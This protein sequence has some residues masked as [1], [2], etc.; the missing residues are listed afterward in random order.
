MSWAADYFN[1]HYFDI[2]GPGGRL[3]QEKLMKAQEAR[4]KAEK[5][6]KLLIT[7]AEREGKIAAAAKKKADAARHEKWLI[8]FRL[9]VERAIGW[10][11]QQGVTEWSHCLNEASNWSHELYGRDKYLTN[12]EFAPEMKIVMAE[13]ESN[14]YKVD[15]IDEQTSHDDSSAYANSGGE[16]GS[17]HPYHTYDTILKVRW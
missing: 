17:M 15:I 4:E 2:D 12:F 9:L 14:G 1:E 5:A 3:A 7:K 16:C 6:A 8:D 10:R 11:V 13:L